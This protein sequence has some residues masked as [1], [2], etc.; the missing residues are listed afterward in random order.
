MAKNLSHYDDLTLSILAGSE[1]EDRST[2]KEIQPCC[3]RAF[4]GSGC[5]ANRNFLALCFD[6]PRLKSMA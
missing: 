1:S 5:R 2:Q 3:Q 6:L 4:D